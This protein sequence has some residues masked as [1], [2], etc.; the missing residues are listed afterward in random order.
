MVV[1]LVIIGWSLGME[2]FSSKLLPLTIGSIVFVLVA[3]GLWG[4]ILAGN[5]RKATVTD[6]EESGM[7]KPGEEWRGYLLH[8]G[9]V[10]AFFMAIYLLGFMIS[11]PLF[12][13]SYMRRLGTRWHVAITFAVLTSMFIYVI[14]EFAIG[15]DL[16][17]GL[18]FTWFGY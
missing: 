13:L 12:I 16:Y 5:E 2:Y 8:G 6:A 10:A 9:W 7:E 11:M 1:M 3:I 17:R 15:I 18:V 14:F 4:E